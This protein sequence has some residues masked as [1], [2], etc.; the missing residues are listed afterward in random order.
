M[1]TQH[2]SSGGKSDRERELAAAAA[3]RRSK[4]R[5]RRREREDALR[6][7]PARCTA[8]LCSDT[9][10]ATCTLTVRDILALTLGLLLGVAT[11]LA[12]AMTSRVH[13]PTWTMEWPSVSLAHVHSTPAT[14]VHT[15]PASPA[16]AAYL[17]RLPDDARIAVAGTLIVM[18]RIDMLS[19]MLD[20]LADSDAVRLAHFVLFVWCNAPAAA[21]CAYMKQYAR[22]HVEF[23]NNTEGVNA[24]IVIPRIRV[25]EAMLAHADRFTYFVEL[26]DDMLFPPA[27][28][29][30]LVRADAPQYGILM[31]F[32]VNSCLAPA[33]FHTHVAPYIVPRDAPPSQRLY[34]NCVQVHP[35][36]TKRAFI[37]DVGYYD[38]A[39]SPHIGE[40]DDLYLRMLR[41]GWKPLAVRSS[42]VLHLGGATRGNLLPDN[43]NLAKFRAKHGI[44]VEEL[45]MNMLTPGCHPAVY[46]PTEVG[47]KP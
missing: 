40:D 12:P 30:D 8:L 14:S 19:G 21:A 7:Q 25:M 34:E 15:A 29:M 31:P 1:S 33:C 44:G 16:S 6:A 23:V 38:P 28:F 4:T 2:H 20:S 46:S 22:M 26:H 35:W 24:G 42:F 36:V 17:Q 41:G 3:A 39:F 27:W 32:I 5:A 47:F 37:E 45:K 43:A 10:V 9:E 13:L 11:V 18:E